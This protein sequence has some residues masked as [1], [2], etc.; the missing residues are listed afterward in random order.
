MLEAPTEI[1]IEKISRSTKEMDFD[2]GVKEGFTIYVHVSLHS[3]NTNVRKNGI[4][5][6]AYYQALMPTERRSPSR[7]DGTNYKMP[8]I[9]LAAIEAGEDRL[10]EFWYGHGATSHKFQVTAEDYNRL[11]NGEAIEIFTDVVEGHR[12]A[13]KIN[14]REQC[15]TSI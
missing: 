9:S 4:R 8:C 7:N 6:F 1:F 3:N 10:Y 11:K 12:H 2:K 14:P 15:Q 13:L 5:S